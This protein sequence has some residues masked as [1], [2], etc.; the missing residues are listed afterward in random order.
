MPMLVFIHANFKLDL[1]YLNVTF[2]EQNPWFKDEFSTEFSFPFDLYLDSELSKNSGFE[3]HYYASNNTIFNGY[4]DRDGLLIDATLKFQGRRGKIISAIINAGLE[5][6]PSFNKKLSELE[7]EIKP[8]FDIIADADA[9]IQL[10]YPETNYNYPMVHTDKYDPESTDFNGFG[11]IINQ[12]RNGSFVENELMIDT[13]LD[14]INNIMQPLPYLM[15]V[16]KKAI[17]HAGYTLAGDI[18]NDV[19]FNRALVFRDGDYYNRSK[20]DEIPFTFKNNEYDSVLYTKSRIEHVLFNKEITIA[21]KGDYIIFGSV[22]N[23]RYRYQDDFFTAKNAT[24]VVIQ[25]FKNNTEIYYN[26]IRGDNKPRKSIYRLNYNVDVDLPVTLEAGDKI[27][28]LKTEGRRDGTPS[29]T[30]DYPEAISLKLIPVRLRNPDGSPI[31]SVLNLKEIDLNRVVPDMTVRD[32]ITALKNLK[33]YDF[34]SNENVIYMNLIENKLD[35]NAAVD[36]TDYDI[37]EPQLDFHQDREFELSFTD[38]NSNPDYKYDSAIVNKSGITINGIKASEAT[39]QIKIDLLPLPV[40]T[41]NSITTA[42]SFDEQN[43]KLRLVFM[44]PVP[45]GGTPVAFQN[46]NVLIPA[47]VEFNFK[48]WL[49]FRIN[50]EAYTWDFIISV[51][52]FREISIQTLVYAYGNYHVLSNIEKERLDHLWWRVNARSESL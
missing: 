22:Y 49:D 48:N 35:R 8:V 34:S 39:N 40:I 38:G 6:F 11:K 29:P 2:S 4:L 20:A 25:I 31:I 23:L 43:S 51:E 37:E 52:R 24:D 14:K 41:R 27:R 12:F 50:S 7:L 9:V 19:D 45:E 46:N 10:G 16:V 47:V 32:V 13:N 3:A 30:P 36:L 28:I 21:K 17:E 15:Y 5:N 26:G 42:F 1:T 33:N 44:N 18:L